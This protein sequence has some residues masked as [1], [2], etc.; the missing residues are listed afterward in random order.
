MST[1]S[2]EVPVS[3]RRMYNNKYS[4][5]TTIA[6]NNYHVNEIENIV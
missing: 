6:N 1:A 4:S 3:V 2:E 5:I